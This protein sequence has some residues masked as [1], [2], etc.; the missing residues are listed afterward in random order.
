MRQPIE[1][2]QVTR[3]ITVKVGDTLRATRPVR[4][5]GGQVPEDKIFRGETV[6]VETIFQGNLAH[7][8]EIPDRYG[9]YPLDAF[10]LV[11][12]VG[13]PE[14]SEEN[15]IKLAEAHI[16]DAVGP[17]GHMDIRR[18]IA[19]YEKDDAR[20]IDDWQALCTE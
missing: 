10:R 12:R 6:T 8:R 9:P 13:I 2:G 20:F 17:H 14:N 5:I 16:M 1:T 18:L 11:G 7:F 19:R 15:R 3:G 4:F